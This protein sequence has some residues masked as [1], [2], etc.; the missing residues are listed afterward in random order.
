MWGLCNTL[1]GAAEESRGL[2]EDPASGGGIGRKALGKTFRAA[3]GERSAHGKGT[4]GGGERELGACR[5]RAQWGRARR[6]HFEKSEVIDRTQGRAVRHHIQKRQDP[7]V[8]QPAGRA[9]LGQHGGSG[10][11][12]GVCPPR[13]AEEL[14]AA[15]A[16]RTT[17]ASPMTK[18]RRTKHFTKKSPSRRSVRKP[19]TWWH[20]PFGALVTE[21][22]PAWIEVQLEVLL[23]RQPQRLDH[24]YP[25]SR[26][27]TSCSS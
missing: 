11:S 4:R 24:V 22:C 3:G 21:R 6:G 15:L 19:P 1:R 14:R 17:R 12:V 8:A 5:R 2:R 16:A 7:R 25:N 18:R 20:L 27:T 13:C 10:A 9:D 23:Q 26:P